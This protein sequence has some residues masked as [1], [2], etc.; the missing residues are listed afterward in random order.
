MAGVTGGDGYV[1]MLQALLLAGDRYG[2]GRLVEI[3]C[4]LR[5]NTGSGTRGKVAWI[6]CRCPSTTAKF[7]G[8]SAEWRLISLF[9]FGLTY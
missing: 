8:G 7:R 1:D 6:S 5:I 3:C 2:L 4:P 9:K